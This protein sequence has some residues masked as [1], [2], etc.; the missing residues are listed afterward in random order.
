M[1]GL[2]NNEIILSQKSQNSGFFSRK[3]TLYEELKKD[4]EAASQ[5]LWWHL[6]LQKA[7]K[8]RV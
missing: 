6:L 1:R 3:E 2:G 5:M 8:I 7:A 4:N